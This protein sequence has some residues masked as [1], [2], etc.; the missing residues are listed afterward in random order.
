MDVLV[1]RCCG[2]DV[3]KQ[4]VVACRLLPGGKTIRTFPTTTRALRELADW[5]AEGG[6]THVAMESTGSYWKPVYNLLE[7]RFV[8]LVVN[9][10]HL[11]L[12]PGRKSDVKDAEWIADL[13]QHGLLRP[14]YIPSREERELRELTRY[15]DSLTAE[16]SAEVNRI[17]KVLEGANIKLSS[18]AS[19]TLGV[20][21]R[22]M[23]EAIVAG[24]DDGN[25]L[26][27]LAK[28]RLRDK[29]D[30][31][32]EALTGLVQPHQRFMLAQQLG[33]VDELDRRIATLSAEIERR[34]A[35][36][37]PARD[38]LETIPGV[39]R[40]TAEVILAEVGTNIGRFQRAGQL[41]SWAGLCPGLNESAGKNRSGRTPKGNRWLRTA[42]VQAA[43]AAGRTQTYLGAQYRRLRARIGPAKATVAVAHSILVI[44]FHIL[45]DAT[46]YRD[47][48][49]AYF[50]QRHPDRTLKRLT[51][52][53]EELGYR[54]SI[55]PAA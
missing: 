46:D 10:R 16:R 28:G 42:L 13:L 15:R 8:L 43:H 33:H 41:A 30:A 3:H 29:R 32:E 48:G 23:I 7:G 26:A 50:D 37:A 9:T 1:E 27:A 2:L 44:V 38:R 18:V 14:S 4:S 49:P 22:A 53:I 21:G 25:A 51:R 35:P 39:G 5:L 54:V 45:R 20:S 19:N 17:Q 40:R 36:F 12:I 34:Q 31:L 47:L 11:K 24:L 6:C 55:E 52:R